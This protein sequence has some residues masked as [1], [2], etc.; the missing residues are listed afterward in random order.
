MFDLERA[1]PFVLCKQDVVKGESNT[2]IVAKIAW[3]YRVKPASIARYLLGVKRNV[4]IVL[5]NDMPAYTNSVTDKSVDI[6]HRL[7]AAT[8]LCTISGSYS[9]LR[10]FL[11]HGAHG[12]IS[13]NRKWCSQCYQESM[14]VSGRTRNARV[15]DQLYWSLNLA[16]YCHKHL[17]TLSERC[18][19]CYELQPYI[20]SLVEPGFCH[21]CYACL[22]DAPSVIVEEDAQRDSV[23]S[24]LLKYD[25]FYPPYG[26][27]SALWTMSR[28]AKNL[29]AV[30]ELCGDQGGD[31]VALRCGVSKYTLQDWCSCRHGISFESLIKMIDG[32]GLSKA[33]DLFTGT[34]HFCSLVTNQFS[35]AFSFRSKKRKSSS[36]PEISKYFRDVIAGNQKAVSRSG[37]A[38]KFGVSKGMLENAFKA[39][40][41]QVSILYKEQKKLSSL[42][43]SNRLQFEMNK[44]VRRCGGKNRRFDWAHIL[45]ELQDIDFRY[46]T[47]SKLDAAK[48]KAIKLY[49][50]SDKRDQKRD[51]S[52]LICD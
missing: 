24:L 28:L 39:E 12:L 1:A 16:T 33:S 20:S 8:G 52:K 38:E 37:I 40:L 6:D 32:F 35:G 14:K 51:L 22:S 21:Y 23:R 30:V 31:Q 2:S 9:Y 42:K 48:S 27:Q 11:D 15:S 36:L 25:I 10:E 50:E 7:K 47:H 45:A 5:A 34:E 3:K 4:S 46:V 26:E 13:K 29:R 41:G 17:C 44:A 18:G 19:K 43:V 49:V